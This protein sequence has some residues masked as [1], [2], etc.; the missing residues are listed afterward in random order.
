MITNSRATNL[1]FPLMELSKILLPLL[2]FDHTLQTP[3]FKRYKVQQWYFRHDVDI[4]SGLFS[5]VNLMEV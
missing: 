2:L 3:D 5:T 4:L 1:H